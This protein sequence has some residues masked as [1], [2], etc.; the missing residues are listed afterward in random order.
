MI[1]SIIPLVIFKDRE[2]IKC[3]RLTQRPTIK[4]FSNWFLLRV[5]SVILFFVL[6]Y[7]GTNNIAKES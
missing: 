6:H 3:S 2:G 1:I 7:V 5:I 4:K